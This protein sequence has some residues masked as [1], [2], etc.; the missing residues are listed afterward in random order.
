MGAPGEKF[1][2]DA[3]KSAPN[4]PSLPRDIGIKQD[5]LGESIA[6]RK[7]MF[8]ALAERPR[9]RKGQAGQAF[10]E[11]PSVVQPHIRNHKKTPHKEA[12]FCDWW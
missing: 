1:G 11:P 4:W 5:W 7:W 8:S 2:A 9:T 6:W 3:P 10:C 12:F